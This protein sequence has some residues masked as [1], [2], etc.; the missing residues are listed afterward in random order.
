MVRELTSPTLEQTSY[1]NWDTFYALIQDFPHKDQL[2]ISFAYQKVKTEHAMQPPRESGERYF[3]HLRAAALILI[4]VG[5]TDP[6]IIIAGLGHDLVED[7]PK[8][9]PEGFTNSERNA[10]AFKKLQKWFGERAAAMIL[11]V[12]KL[13]VDDKEVFTKEQAHQIYIAR[14][15][16]TPPE[17]LLVKMADRLHNIRTLGA[18]SIAKQ[19]EIIEETRTVYLPLFERAKE[20]YPVETAILLEQM[21]LAM[22]EVEANYRLL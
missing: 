14:L 19:K 1:E 13:F 11:D 9:K 4:K 18:R 22:Q 17:S 21:E 16:Q 7:T 10:N 3:E 2:K 6:D 5:I 20:K 15:Y 12:T 8:F